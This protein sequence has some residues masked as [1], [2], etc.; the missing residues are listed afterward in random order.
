[1]SS[2][3][4][5]TEFLEVLREEVIESLDNAVVGAL[6]RGTTPLLRRF[7]REAVALIFQR[8]ILAEQMEEARRQAKAEEN[9]GQEA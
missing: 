4:D 7:L 9:T 3:V 6:G 8:R 5:N 1:M 2:T